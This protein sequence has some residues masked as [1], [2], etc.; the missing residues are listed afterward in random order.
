MHRRTA[1]IIIEEGN[2]ITQ[3]LIEALERENVEDLLMPKMKFIYFVKQ[4][5]ARL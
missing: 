5:A 2:I 3:D 1:E 4:T